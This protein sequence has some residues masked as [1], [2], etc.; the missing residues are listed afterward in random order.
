MYVCV[1]N[2]TLILDSA[3]R[4]SHG[5]FFFRFVVLEPLYT[6]C[7]D[8]MV[9]YCGHVVFLLW[10]NPLVVQ[11]SSVLNNRNKFG[12]WFAVYNTTKTR[13]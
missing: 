7:N 3:P 11:V 5:S 4:V 1:L 12:P 6:R 8:G 13:L 2:T 10:R 9:Q